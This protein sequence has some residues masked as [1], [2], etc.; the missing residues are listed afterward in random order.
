VTMPSKV[1][2]RDALI[3]RLH[4][5]GFAITNRTIDSHIRNLRAKFASVGAEDVIETRA[6]IGYRLGVCG[7]G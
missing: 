7:A 2:S 3:D 6:G 5:P 1:F 4:G